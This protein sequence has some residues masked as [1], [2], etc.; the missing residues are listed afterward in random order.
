MQTTNQNRQL[1]WFD[2]IGFPGPIPGKYNAV[3]H[4]EPMLTANQ[5]YKNKDT[6]LYVV[7][8]VVSCNNQPANKL[9]SWV[10]KYNKTKDQIQMDWT[11]VTIQQK[12]RQKIQ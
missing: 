1:H 5:N 7:P 12:Q 2:L 6:T 10:K 4:V 3:C 9:E 8:G 11:Y